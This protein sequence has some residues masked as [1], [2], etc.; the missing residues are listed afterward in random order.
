MAQFGRI[1]IIFF[2]F[3]ERFPD[4]TILQNIVYFGA[5]KIQGLRI[6]LQQEM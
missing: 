5:I 2:V 4:E 6:G 3:S 1:R